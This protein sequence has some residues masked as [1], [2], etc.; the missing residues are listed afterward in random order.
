MLTVSSQYRFKVDGEWKI[1]TRQESAHGSPLNVPINYFFAPNQP[2]SANRADKKKN[3]K[4]N[5]KKSKAANGDAHES[6]DEHEDDD[7]VEHLTEEKGVKAE[8]G[9]TCFMLL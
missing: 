2:P 9:C 3:K 7:V 5:K 8:V 1:D 6:E 4:K